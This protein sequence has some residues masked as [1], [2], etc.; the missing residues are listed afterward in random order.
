MLVQA[1]TLETGDR[2]GRQEILEP[3]GVG[4]MG[5]VY[6][7]RDT[8]LERDVA[9]KVLPEA[10]VGDADR[11]GRF[12]R[13]A[14]A[15]ARLSHPNILEIHDYGREGDIAYSVTELLEGDTLRERLGGGPLSWRKVN[16]IGAAIADGLGAAHE[17]GIVHRD[18]KP[19]NVFL[20]ADGRVKI[21]DFGLA[22]RVGV[23]VGDGGTED[24]TMTRH[25][26][27]GTVLGKVGYMSPEQVRGEA[28][29]HR[30]DIF[31][32]GR[33]LFELV[34]GRRAFARDSTADTMAAIL[35]E[36]PTELSTADA[37]LP[38]ELERTI[39]RCL[40][41]RPRAKAAARKALA[42][43]ESLVEAHVSLADASYHHDHDWAGA[44]ASFRRV[45]QLEPGNA[46]AYVWYSDLLAAQGRFDEVIEE[47]K[48]AKG[49]DPLS[50]TTRHNSAR[51]FYFARRFDEVIREIEQIC[52]L[53]PDYQ[54]EMSAPALSQMGLH[55]QAIEILQGIAADHDNDPY[56]K[57]ALARVYAAAERA[58]EARTALEE[59]EA[60]AE[61]EYVAPHLIALAHAALGGH[62]RALDWLER[63]YQVRDASLIWV[64]VDPGFDG[65]RSDPRFVDLLRRMKRVE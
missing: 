62:D 30:S 4:G 32:L 19:A 7:A 54:D 41:K 37:A 14:N 49:L 2:L 35:K 38:P 6:R 44:E 17:A 8:E 53:Y 16:E 18:L 61:G 42:L 29:D 56:V 3:L 9:I 25:T 11:L 65:V 46:R 52:E 23:G 48:V 15:V 5:E 33:V 34:F 28:V 13:E 51:W 45:F 36:E 10:V 59:L 55:G 50:R 31:S 64:N 43:D 63:D 21:L 58:S 20:T 40:E 57:S 60:L 27:P 24:P 12:E 39:V 47:V 22:G 26:D 1:M